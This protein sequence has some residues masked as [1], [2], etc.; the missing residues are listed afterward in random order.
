ME[1]SLSY[2]ERTKTAP[3]PRFVELLELEKAFLNVWKEAPEP[4]PDFGRWFYQEDGPFDAIQKAVRSL[5][6]GQDAA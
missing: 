4:K 5:N 6:N 1:D 3:V 2:L